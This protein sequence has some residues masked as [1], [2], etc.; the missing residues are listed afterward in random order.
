MVTIADKSYLG[1]IVQEPVYGP[2]IADKI[3]FDPGLFCQVIP[4]RCGHTNRRHGAVPGTAIEVMAPSA[5]LS[6]LDLGPRPFFFR[7]SD[8]NTGQGVTL[9][10]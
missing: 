1:S 3:I 8:L 9:V 4:E 7:G 2:V 5:C 6:R 10:S